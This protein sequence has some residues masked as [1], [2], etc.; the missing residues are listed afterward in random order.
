MFLCDTP[1]VCGVGSPLLMLVICKTKVYIY[2]NLCMT[3]KQ[4]LMLVC[5]R[6]VW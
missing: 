4:A 6:N 1:K 3:F 5:I 2:D